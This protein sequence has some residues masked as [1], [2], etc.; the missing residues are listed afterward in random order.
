M[1]NQRKESAEEKD[2]PSTSNQDPDK[3]IIEKDFDLEIFNT[4]TSVLM[5]D[6]DAPEIKTTLQF[7]PF[8]KQLSIITFPAMFFYATVL[9]LQTINII[10]I[11]RKYNNEDMINAIGVTNV[12]M[13][14]TL[15]SIYMGIVGGIE[16]VCANAYVL[17]KYKL[18]GYYYHRARIIA[19]AV[20]IVIVI[21]HLCSVQ[22]VLKLFGLTQNVVRLS[23]NYIYSCLIYVFFDIQTVCIFR[24]LNVVDKSHINF[25]I[26]LIS[27]VLHPLW[28][29]I[30]ISVLDYDVI[31]AGISFTISKIIACVL[32]VAYFWIYNPLPEANFWINK[33][34]FKWSGIK[35]YIK[36]SIGQAL[37]LCAEW[38]GFEIQAII[39]INISEHV[40]TVH[41]LCTEMIGLFYSYCVGCMISI[42]IV[43]SE[44][45]THA[46]VSV[47]KRACFYSMAF[48]I[49]GDLILLAIYFPLREPLLRLFIQTPSVLED[50]YPVLPYLGIS[51]FFDMI[52][53]CLVSVYRGINKHYFASIYMFIHYYVL[54]V[55]LSWYMGKYLNWG[56]LGLWYGICISDC[57]AAIIYSL[58]LTCVNL[59]ASQRETIIRLKQDL[60]MI[61][62]SEH[63]VESS[64]IEISFIQKSHEKQSK[65]PF[66]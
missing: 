34:C 63:E 58:G 21:I 52:Q 19:Y 4:R 15:M 60:D 11:G 56:C 30:F 53:V 40:Y 45:I 65:N 39:A 54:M 13:N 7:W 64:I 29:Y 41:V 44:L 46:S 48:A 5:R 27:L 38:W 9:L 36:F 25:I 18:M 16:I 22:H 57:L 26:L 14:C 3:Q 55:V 23:S 6:L 47:I 37:L 32:A 61:K 24:F 12:Y 35:E 31:G 28:N 49:A 42:S 2:Q 1:E 8:I 10:F 33:N 59:M 20:T 62:K 51:H 66:A 50:G 17:R 43:I